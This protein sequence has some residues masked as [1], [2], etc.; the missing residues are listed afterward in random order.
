MLNWGLNEKS[1]DFNIILFFV[2]FL[3][4]YFGVEKLITRIVS[5]VLM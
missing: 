3:K 5:Y 1:V 4:I 2:L